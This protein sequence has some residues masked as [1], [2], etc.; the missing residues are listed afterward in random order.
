M[1]KTGRNDPCPCGSGKK[2]KQCCLSVDEKRLNQTGGDRDKAVP[3]AID[4]LMSLHERAVKEA[5]R[6]GFFD[7]L[8]EGAYARLIQQPDDIWRG[9]MTNAMEWLLADGSLV[10]RKR[11]YFVSELLLGKG[12]PLFSAEQRHWIELLTSTS[13]GLYEVIEVTPDESILLKDAVFSEQA[14]ILVRERAGSQGLSKFDLLAARILPLED[15]YVLSG[16]MY[17]FPRLRSMDFIAELQHELQGLA[18]DDPETQEVMSV[19][20]PDFWLRL[21]T[22]TFETPNLFDAVSGDPMLL[23][24]DHYRVQDWKA[25]E[26]AMTGEASIVGSRKKGWD[27]LF[28]GDDGLQRASLSI[29]LGQQKDRIKVFYRTQSY[30]DQG[31]PWFDAIAG[32]AVVFVGREITDPKGM[33]ANKKPGS[34]APQALSPSDIP[35]EAYA[36]IIEKTMRKMYA[37]WAD[38]PIPALDNQTPRAAIQTPEGLEQVR[39][40]LNTYEHNEAK[41]AKEQNRPVIDFDFLWQELGIAP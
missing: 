38:E 36:E 9:I 14:P 17:M 10:I 39:F 15:H 37:N 34:L 40:L 11:E 2:F 1:K 30:A 4:W 31:R 3:K 13:L 6:N 24:T 22:A 27:R 32:S 33:L 23:I 21:M 41:L 12:G 20:I 8:D 29:E 18:P 35:P 5:L 7:T 28:E 16:A 26:Q 19:F 25:L